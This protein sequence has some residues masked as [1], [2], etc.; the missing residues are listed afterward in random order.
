MKK[1]IHMS[2][3]H[4]GTD[5]LSERLRRVVDNLIFEKG[6]KAGEE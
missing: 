1:I 2:D 5:D 4:T 3:P 6:D